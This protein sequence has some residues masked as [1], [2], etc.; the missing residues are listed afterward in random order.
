MRAPFPPTFVGN[1]YR[2]NL[3]AEAYGKKNLGQD[4]K[5]RVRGETLMMKRCVDL[6]TMAHAAGADF[7]Y[8][9]PACFTDLESAPL[10]QDYARLPSRHVITT[11]SS[12]A[13]ALKATVPVQTD[14]VPPPR[15]GN[16]IIH[17]L[18]GFGGCLAISGSSLP[19][20]PTTPPTSRRLPAVGVS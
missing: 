12:G 14:R 4:D 3:G 1:Q 5:N 13:F 7:V 11:F 19:S 2:S 8:Y 15:L 17:A 9:L 6:A 18:V 10:P 20:S 16:I